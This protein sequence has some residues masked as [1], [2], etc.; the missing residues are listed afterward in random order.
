[1]QFFRDLSLSAFVAGFVAVLVAAG[2][3]ALFVGQYGRK[4]KA[5]P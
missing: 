4:P 2:T 3:L 1:M 5:S